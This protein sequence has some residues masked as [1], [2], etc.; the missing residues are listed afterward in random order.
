MSLRGV[1]IVDFRRVPFSR[2][3]RKEPQ[4]DIYYDKRPEEVAAIV[5]R[6]IVERNGIRP[7]DVDDLV[8]GMAL[9]TGEGFLYGGRHVVFAAKL[10]V[11]VPAAAVDRQCASSITSV[12][13]GANEI[14]TGM[15]DVVIAGGVEHMSRVPMYDNPHVVLNPKFFTDEYA[16]YELNV[17]YV[18]G[19]TA[20]RLA[21]EAKIGREEMDRWSLRSHQLAYKAQQEGYFKGEIIPVEVEQEGRKVV[22]DRDMSVRPDTSL[23]K[24]AQL[25]P[26]FRADGVITA[27]NSSPLN[28]GASYVLLMSER[29]VK[30]YGLQPMARLVSYGFA[31]VPPAV[32]G[33][34]PVP[35]S[36]KALERAGLTVRDI[37]L[38]EINEAFAVVTLYAIKELGI[39]EDRVNRRGGAI[40]IGH[41]LGATGARIIGTLA[42]QLQL[43]GKDRGVATL[44]VGGGQGAAVVVERV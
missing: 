26:A 8:T 21:E 37:D 7:E 17:G 2:F 40:A 38:W 39:E 42:R 6:D 9:Q 14:A 34:G 13:M 22:V 18:M 29:A 1:Y 16:F 36:R 32:M 19:L 25:P 41:P 4:R 27:G 43:E 5:V 11:T 44:C 20:E 3:T 33:K 10:P 12:V 23:E 31:G 35:A 15:A 28:T 30:R 24:L